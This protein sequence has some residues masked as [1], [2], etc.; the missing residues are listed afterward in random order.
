MSGN[1]AEESTEYEQTQSKTNELQTFL[2]LTVIL[3]PVVA[4]VSVGGYGFAVWI[5][6]LIFGPPGV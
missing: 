5:W 2:L 1:T 3:A 6:Q 4:V